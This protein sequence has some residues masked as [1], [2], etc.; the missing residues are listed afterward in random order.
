LEQAQ[1]E[2]RERQ[3][4]NEKESFTTWMREQW[5]EAEKDMEKRLRAT[6]EHMRKLASYSAW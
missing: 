5:K 2:K 6:A 3:Y 4:Q 1:K